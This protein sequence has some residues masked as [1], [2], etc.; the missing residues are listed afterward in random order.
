MFPTRKQWKAWTALNKLSYLAQVAAIFS[1]FPTMT[2]AWLSW[3]EARL[4]R[5]DQ[6]KFFQSINAPEIELKEIKISPT[7]TSE[8]LINFV[9]KNSGSSP[10][11]NVNLYFFRVLEEKNPISS[12]EDSEF[13]RNFTINKDQEFSHYLVTVENIENRVG[14]RPKRIFKFDPLSS[15]SNATKRDNVLLLI[16]YKDVFDNQYSHLFSFIVEAD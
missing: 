8:G 7:K 14:F 13:L 3:R 2:F 12:T 15:E 16:T 6:I 4:A 9:L 5:Q 10:A 1:L 11:K